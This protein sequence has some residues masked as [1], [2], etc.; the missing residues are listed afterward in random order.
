MSREN[1]FKSVYEAVGV[2]DRVL[3]PHFYDGIED[4]DLV[5]RFMAEKYGSPGTACQL[6]IVE[7][8]CGTGRITARLAPYARRLVGVDYSPAM[9]E[10]FQA[11]Y[12]HA[13]THCLDTRE[14]V[15]GLLD[16]GQADAF[17]VVAAF[18]SL[19]YPLGE[20]FEQ[21]TA[22]GIRPEPDTGSARRRAGQLVRDLLRLVAPGGH[23]LVLFFDSETREQHMVT[24]LWEK[25]APF[26]EGG[27]GYT[28]QLL[29]DE[30]YAAERRGQGNLTHVRRAGV[31]TASD[32]DAARAWFATVHLKGM[33]ALVDDPQAQRDIDQFV[34]ACSRPS[35]QVDIPT[36]VHV[37]DFTM[38][39]DRARRS[40]G[41]EA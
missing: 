24:R 35:G 11:R 26:P 9:I 3:L 39:Q 29:L 18:W 13:R 25:L 5:G 10:A 40:R 6:S 38:S 1:G 30:L 2:Y 15:A 23:L 28:R 8:G 41:A 32:R 20:C 19:S 34:T 36:G 37:I 12:P 7:F 16:D 31:A 14:A 21:M 4:I 33:P 27:R 22:D 17:D